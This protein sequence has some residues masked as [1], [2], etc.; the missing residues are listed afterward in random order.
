[1]NKLET[2]ICYD[3]LPTLDDIKEAFDLIKNNSKI[4]VKIKWFDIYGGWKEINVTPQNV[5][6]MD[7]IKFF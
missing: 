7:Y 4:I 2:Y 3:G 5:C 6:D 1:M